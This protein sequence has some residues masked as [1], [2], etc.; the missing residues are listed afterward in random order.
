MHRCNL[1]AFH[2][3]NH[4]VNPN[5]TVSEIWSAPE[6]KEEALLSQ[7]MLVSFGRLLSQAFFHGFDQFVD[8][9]YPFS[10]QTVITNGVDWSFFAYQLNTMKLDRKLNFD[11]FNIF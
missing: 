8:L 1:L 5:R 2:P 7:A 4:L 9:E 3:R 11:C 10:T 6:E